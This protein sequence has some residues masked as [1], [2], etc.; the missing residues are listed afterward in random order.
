MS[1]PRDPDLVIATWLED[2]PRALPDATRRAITVTTEH[3]R[4]TRRAWWP[5]LRT[6]PM[7][8]NARF[9]AAG[10][11]RACSAVT[12]AATLPDP[13]GRA[14]PVGPPAIAAATTKVTTRVVPA[15]TAP[16]AEQTAAPGMLAV[17]YDTADGTDHYVMRPDGSSRLQLT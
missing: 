16:A 2:G 15:P 5:P 13:C 7:T 8:G 17:A 4:Q 12:G 10:G 3:T 9:A 14:S 6:P 1:I 11:P